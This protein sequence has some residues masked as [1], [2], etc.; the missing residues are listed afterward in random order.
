MILLA[1]SVAVMFILSRNDDEKNMSTQD[2]PVDRISESPTDQPETDITATFEVH[3]NG[4]KRVFTNP[5]YH[6]LDADVYLTLDNPSVVHVKRAGVAWSDLFETLPMQLT[7]ECLTTGTG[8]SFCQSNTHRLI[9]Y[10]NGQESPAALDSIIKQGDHLM[11]VYE[12][13]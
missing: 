1:L 5:M 7:S 8:Q 4:T 2:S 3:T 11:V 12:S 6:D 9:F 13:Y 10:L